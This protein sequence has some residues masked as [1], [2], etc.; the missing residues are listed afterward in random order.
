MRLFPAVVACLL[1]LWALGAAAP[2]TPTPAPTPAATAAPERTWTIRGVERAG[3]VYAPAKPSAAAPVVFVFHGHGGTARFAQ[4]GW[5]VEEKWPEAIVVYLQG[6]P[7]KGI[8]DPEGK[9]NGWETQRT[10]DHDRDLAFFDAALVT[11]RKEH[12]V[13]EKKIFVAGHSN[14]GSMTYLLWAKRGDLLAAAGPSSSVPAW[15]RADLKPKPAIAV[16]GRKDPIVPF[17]FQSAGHDALKKVDGCGPDGK[18][19]A[20]GGK[21]ATWFDGKDGVPFVAWVHDGGHEM[22]KGS[23]EAIVAFF[24]RVAA[25]R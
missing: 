21:E 16:A 5:R 24:K 2:A 4:R 19:W 12:K 6:L 25:G 17:A 8:T 18:P 7:S 1:S 11:V 13:D 3:L 15:M 9:K 14:G 10:S 23:V 22:P 20:D